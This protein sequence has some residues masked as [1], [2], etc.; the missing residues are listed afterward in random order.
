MQIESICVTSHICG[1]FEQVS[2]GAERRDKITAVSVRRAKH[3]RLLPHC[4]G[5]RSG[6]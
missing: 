3:T 4:A 2:M 1:G 5:R 6:A